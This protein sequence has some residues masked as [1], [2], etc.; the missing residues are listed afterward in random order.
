MDKY[1]DIG[2]HIFFF[3]M[4]CK[5]YAVKCTVKTTAAVVAKFN[6]KK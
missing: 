1:I 5:K 2:H 3:P 4:H 6:L